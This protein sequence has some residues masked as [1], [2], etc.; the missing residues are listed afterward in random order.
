M[1]QYRFQFL[2]RHPRIRALTDPLKAVLKG[3]TFPEE[4]YVGVDVDPLSLS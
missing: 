3:M 4:V 1:D 2:V